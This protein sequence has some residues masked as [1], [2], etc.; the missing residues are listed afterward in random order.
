MPPKR[1]PDVV[2]AGFAAARR[3]RPRARSR[4]GF[5]AAGEWRLGTRQPTQARWDSRAD[6]AGRRRAAL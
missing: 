1:K 3:S 6:A 4:S 2:R 5:A